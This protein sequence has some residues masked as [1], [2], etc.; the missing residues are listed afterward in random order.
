MAVGWSLITLS[1]WAFS[2]PLGAELGVAWAGTAVSLVAYTVVFWR[3]RRQPWRPAPLRARFSSASPAGEAPWAVALRIA[4]GSVLYLI[5]ALATALV[6]AI[7]GPWP[8]AER[9]IAGGLMVP[10]I[11][12]LGG[13]H[14]AA[15]T[16]PW[17]TATVPAVL[18]LLASVGYISL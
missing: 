8:E 9:M 11:W 10:L 15:D 3:I 12:A 4:A 18:T 13:L 16:Q 17:R 7:K 5:A 14:A 6:M 2:R 1:V